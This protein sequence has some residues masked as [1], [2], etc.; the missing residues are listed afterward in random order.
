MPDYL[1]AVVE[2][3]FAP[4]IESEQKDKRPHWL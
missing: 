3:N 1:W 4:V 2:S